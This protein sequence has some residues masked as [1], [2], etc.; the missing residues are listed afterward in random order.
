MSDPRQQ[1]AWGGELR[2]PPWL[3]RLIRR[4]KASDSP[5]RAHERGWETRHP[6]EGPSILENVDRALFGGFS[7]GHPANREEPR[8]R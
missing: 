7:E 5:E 1:E 2:V 6:A 4:P 8:G 3:R